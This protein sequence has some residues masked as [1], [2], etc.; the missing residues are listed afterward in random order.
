MLNVI[1]IDTGAELYTL[2]I[3]WVKYTVKKAGE[4]TVY[5]VPDGMPDSVQMAFSTPLTI[6][7][8]EKVADFERAWSLFCTSANA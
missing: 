2:P 6:S 8:P 1:E 4:L 5:I 3:A 7:A